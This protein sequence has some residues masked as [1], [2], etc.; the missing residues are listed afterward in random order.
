M[1]QDVKDLLEEKYQLFANKEFIATDPISVP[2]R[3]KRL[4]DIEIAAFWTAIFSWG[5]RKTIINKATT[6]FELMGDSPYDFIMHH[7]SAQ[8]RPFEDFVHRTFNGSDALYFID[9]F[10]HHYTNHKSLEDAFNLVESHDPSME[11]RLIAFE[12]YF[13]SLPHLK[14]TKKHIAT[15]ARKSTCKRINMFLRWMVRTNHEGIDFGLW[16]TIERSDLMI[17]FD[18]HVERVARS[19]GLLHRKQRDW[20]AVEELTEQLRAF[21]PIDPVKY[22]F[23]L[24]G[25]GV[26]EKK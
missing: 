4:Y 7:T 21:D 10:K 9:F 2:K 23:A 8:L 20:K 18:V 16:E 3:Y 12:Q 24:F 15:P 25:M 13:F 5:Q 17:P 11:Q 22:D 19:I 26:M 14:R 6:L 1:N